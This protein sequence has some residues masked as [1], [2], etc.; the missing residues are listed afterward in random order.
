MAKGIY[1]LT[2]NR[3]GEV[4]VGQTNNLYYREKQHEEDLIHHY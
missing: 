4:Y 1:K 2:N 3:T